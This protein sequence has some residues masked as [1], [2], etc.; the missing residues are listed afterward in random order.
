MLLQNARIGNE[1]LATAVQA[2]SQGKVSII[3]GANSTNSITA[4]EQAMEV[5]GDIT[6]SGSGTLLT[7]G[8]F[9]TESS[10]TMNAGNLLLKKGDM[11]TKGNI[12][13]VSYTHLPTVPKSSQALSCPQKSNVVQ[14]LGN[15][16]DPIPVSYTHL[17]VYKRQISRKR[18][19]EF[20]EHHNDGP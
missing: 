4:A 20:L 6:V 14:R 2:K 10:L 9:S 17:D 3:L 16:H 11:R 8:N 18:H 12:T 1:K 15:P 19:T 7:K 13:P 5:S